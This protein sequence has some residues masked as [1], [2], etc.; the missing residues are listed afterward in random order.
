MKDRKKTEGQSL[1]SEKP[2]IETPTCINSVLHIPTTY[3]PNILCDINI[4]SV[5]IY[6]YLKAP[7]SRVLLGKL[8]VEQMIKEFPQL[9]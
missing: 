8:M 2:V 3:F 4:L 7:W 1:S 6:S 9:L 5:L